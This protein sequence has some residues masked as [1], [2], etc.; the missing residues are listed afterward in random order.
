MTNCT[1]VKQEDVC[2][3]CGNNNLL[4][5]IIDGIP[6]F[7]DTNTAEEVGHFLVCQ[8]CGYRINVNLE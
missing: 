6:N 4:F 5:M 7:E 2:P 3:K 8:D 1:P